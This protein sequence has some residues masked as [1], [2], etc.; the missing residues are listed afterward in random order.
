MKDLKKAKANIMLG[1]G[2]LLFAVGYFLETYNFK[3]VYAKNV[4]D[5]AFMPRI[6]AVLIAVCAA[7]VLVKGIRELHAI[8]KEQ[9]KASS[10]EKQVS[11]RGFVRC[12]ICF[13]I[14]LATAICM[15]PLG[16]IL[17]MIPAMFGLF[18]V[19]SVKGK[20]KIGLYILLSIVT[21]LVLFFGFYYGFQTLLPPGV[22]KPLLTY[23]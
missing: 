12:V 6:I 20:R 3:I 18:M 13:L 9:R 1:A 14:M 11:R 2:T 21:P 4:I 5:A 19:A 22:L 17:T 8:P 7:W 23:L 16:F 10:E 15:K